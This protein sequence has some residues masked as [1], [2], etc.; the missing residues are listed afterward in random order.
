VCQL[1]ETIATNNRSTDT[2]PALV[3]NGQM[4]ADWEYVRKTTNY[5]SNGP[6]APNIMN[7]FLVSPPNSSL[8]QG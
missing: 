8:T 2:F 7:P 6:G 4:T 1:F 3:A 5:Q